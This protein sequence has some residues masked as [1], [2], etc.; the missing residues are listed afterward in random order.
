MIGRGKPLLLIAGAGATM[1][2]WD[3]A[4]LRQ[5]SANHTVILFDNRG[6][7]LTS[8]GV[9]KSFSVSQYANDTAGLLDALQ[10]RK[11]S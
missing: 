3:S 11:P 6:I 8:A 9:I 1:N 10:N 4:V 7:G 2:A 5:L